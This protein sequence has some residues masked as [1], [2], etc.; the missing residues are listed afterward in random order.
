MVGSVVKVLGETILF[1][2]M[3]NTLNN[4]MIMNPIDF[5]FSRSK[6]MVIIILNILIIHP[7]FLFNKS[8]GLAS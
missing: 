8:L 3:K 2:N 6:V 5:M 4:K 1:P 7:A